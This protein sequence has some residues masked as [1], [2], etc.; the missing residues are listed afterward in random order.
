[1]K[2]IIAIFFFLLPFH[3]FL[4]T[5]LKCK[6]W[7]NTNIIRFWKEII[8]LWLFFYT[9]FYVLKKYKYKISKIYKNNYLLWTITAFAIVS[10]FFIFLP[11]SILELFDQ[12]NK[13]PWHFKEIFINFLKT[14]KVKAWFLGYK[15]DVFFL[16]AIVIGF[17]FPI[18][19]KNIRFY[20]RTTIAS[21]LIIL[22]IFIPVYLFW[23]LASFYS[24]FGYTN[25]V[26]TYNPNSC[27]TY[28]QNVEWWH[29]RFQATF[30]GP[31]RFSVFL[32]I[33]YLLYLWAILSSKR[34]LEKNKKYM[35]WIF[36]ILYLTALF[37]SYTKT[38]FLGFFIWI[39]IFLL[40]TYREKFWKQINKKFLFISWILFSL[41]L[42][43]ILYIKRD[44][45][46]HLWAMLN[47]LEN[48][49]IS[50]K[51]FFDMPF[52]HGLWIAWP[53]S[54]LWWLINYAA[55]EQSIYFSKL[56]VYKFLPENWYVQILLEQWLLWL[57]LF[58]WI[59][60]ILWV[61]LY[62]IVKNKKDFM[63]IWFFSAF[64]ALIFMANFTHAFEESATS[65]LFFLLIWAY[66]WENL[67]RNKKSN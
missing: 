51:M 36:S 53:A 67:K 19:R 59:L 23:D 52:W 12:L 8:L 63:S 26:S 2:Y 6:L 24:F 9:I 27:L 29:N 31:I 47:R 50:I 54:Q 14:D 17:Y 3:A 62:R 34:F 46:L 43:I 35:I 11:F 61:Y 37:F 58:I 55:P 48:L 16:L 20:L 65:Y 64:I 49:R 22:W 42:W 13:T 5:F 66:I 1:M 10:L 44:L 60:S 56:K 25:D 40:L 4:I 57:G 21:I 38:A 28:S 32:T 41:P 15:Y 33:F 7:I 18:I 39:I 30:W 45:F